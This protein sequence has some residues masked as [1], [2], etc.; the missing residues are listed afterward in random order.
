MSDR[1]GRKAV[2]PCLV[3]G[4][5]GDVSLPSGLRSGQAL[6]LLVQQL[7]TGSECSELST[8]EFG[9]LGAGPQPA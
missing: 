5:D 2:S 4:A 9:I 1:S 8:E 3:L 7:A 6:E